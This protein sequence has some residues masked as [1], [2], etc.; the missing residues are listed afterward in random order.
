MVQY[1]NQPG[2]PPDVTALI[3]S[4]ETDV[5]SAQKGS[6]VTNVRN[7]P[8]ISKVMNVRNAL[9]DSREKNVD[10]VHKTITDKIVVMLFNYIIPVVVHGVT[11]YMQSIILF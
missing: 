9:R 1:V 7:V 6:K 11:K 8:L 4:R 2:H 10:N 3:I 5:T